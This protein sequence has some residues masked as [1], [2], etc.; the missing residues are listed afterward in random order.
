MLKNFR[1]RDCYSKYYI[2][3]I[4]TTGLSHFHNSAFFFHLWAQGQEW[5]HPIFSATFSD[6]NSAQ[7]LYK[8]EVVMDSSLAKFGSLEHHLPPSPQ[9]RLLKKLL[10]VHSAET[11]NDLTEQMS[12]TLRPHWTPYLSAKKYLND[13]APHL[14]VY[15]SKYNCSSQFFAR[16]CRIFSVFSNNAIL[17][18]KQSHI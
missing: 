2:Y 1:A 6:W 14:P 15:A 18:N 11:S 10:L 5:S 12:T 9:A 16:I 4:V 7:G 3:F 13:I 17:H 8:V